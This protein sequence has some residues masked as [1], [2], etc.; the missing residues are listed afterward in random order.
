M[1]AIRCLCNLMHHEMGELLVVK[2]YDEILTLI[3]QLN[4]EN[5]QLKHVQVGQIMFLFLR[6]KSN[7]VTVYGT[8]LYYSVLSIFFIFILH[9][10]QS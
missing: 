5:L 8:N 1:M 3:Q 9:N 6:F 10:P 7:Y 2:H 4:S